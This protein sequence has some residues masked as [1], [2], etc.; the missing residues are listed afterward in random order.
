MSATPASAAAASAKQSAI[1]QRVMRRVRAARTVSP[2]LSGE[3][4]ALVVAVLA[5]WGIGREVWVA[6]VFQNAP[7]LA[8]ISAASHFWLAAFLN[9]RSTVQ[10]LVLATLIAALYLVREF[11]RAVPFALSPKAA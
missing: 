7:S 1:E 3:A 2:L 5:L 9:T 10:L 11:A 4:L 6:R 8:H